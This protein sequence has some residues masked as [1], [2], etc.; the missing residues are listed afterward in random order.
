MSD[1]LQPLGLQHSRLSCLTISQTLLKLMSIESAMPSN[2][3]IFGHPLLLLPSVFPSIRAFF[4]ASGINELLI[5]TGFEHDWW[6][7][8]FHWE[9]EETNSSTFPVVQTKKDRYHMIH[10]YVESKK[11]IQ[12]YLSNRNRLI[13][14]E[15]KLNGYQSVV[16]QSHLI[17]FEPL[18]CSPP[19]FSVR[20]IFQERILKWVAICLLQGIF[21]I[22]GSNLHFLCLLHCRWILYLLSH[23]G[24]GYQREEG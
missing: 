9:F 10:L 17:L 5:P 22:Q 6:S 23:W 21:L 12:M 4:P 20:G 24:R 18:D 2:H 19:S 3:L 14:F 15:N 7:L 11:I 1:S 16:A 13:D 8:L